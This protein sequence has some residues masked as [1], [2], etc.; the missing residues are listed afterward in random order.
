MH[1]T[2]AETLYIHRRRLDV[3]QVERATALRLS[4]WLYVEYEQDKRDVPPS[5]RVDLVLTDIEKCVIYRRREDW[6]QQE[7]ADDIGC[8][9][10]WVIKMEN[11]T[12]NPGLL[13]DYWS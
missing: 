7:V 1:L 3:N 6:T 10:L 9:R 2:D 11:G 4:E 8:S 5:M 13:L 12:A